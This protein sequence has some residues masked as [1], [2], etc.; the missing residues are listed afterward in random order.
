M[1]KL[2]LNCD[3]WWS[4]RDPNPLNTSQNHW[5][6]IAEINLIKT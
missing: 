3:M 1:P 4:K 5:L 6:V 2:L